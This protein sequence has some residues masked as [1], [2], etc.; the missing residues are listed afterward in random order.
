MMMKT[1]STLTMS[2]RFLLLALCCSSS[3]IVG[4]GGKTNLFGGFAHNKNDGLLQGVPTTT[5]SNGVE[6]PLV[7]LG[8]GNLQKNR[9]ENMIYEGLKSD[10][11]IHLIDTGHASLNEKEIAQGITTGVKRFKDTQKMDDKERIQVHVVTKVWYTHLGYER[12]KLS[13]EE[14]LKDLD[15]ATKDP[16]V[17]L[18][19]HI[20]IHWPQ[21]Y[22]AVEWMNCAEDE[23]ALPVYVKNAGPPPHLDPD[24]AW[25]GSW[26]ALEDMYNSA[27]YPSIAGIG[28]SN[29]REQDLE[30]L[31]AMARVT[32]HMIQLNVWSLLMDPQLVAACSRNSIHIQCYNVMNGILGNAFTTKHAFH[33]LLLVANN[34]RKESAATDSPL[35]R[36]TAAQVVLKW[37][38]QFEFS[39][40]PRTSNLDRL[41]DN[42]AI[43]I[44][45][46]PDLNEENLETTSKA[47]EAILTSKDLEQDVYVNAT[48]HAQSQ[49]MYLF[50]YPGEHGDAI[51]IAHIPKGSSVKDSTHPHHQYRLYD[52]KFFYKYCLQGISRL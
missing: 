26:K 43:S 23:N 6:L 27:D 9:I 52:C 5:L 39:V 46:I 11:R 18:K 14:S 2:G 31:I 47:I 37:L 45:S 15:E 8:V 41:T 22:D 17:D 3:F 34:L 51:Q 19:V 7:G 4:V 32:P 12:T 33:H 44:Q 49:D 48:F 50:Y 28:I 16:N 13:V 42:S 30:E 1:N 25:K 21:C 24:N 10:H 40:V 38:T 35:E 29:Y 20:L 36:I